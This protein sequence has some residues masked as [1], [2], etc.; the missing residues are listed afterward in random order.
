M[1]IAIVGLGGSYSDYI[2]ARVAS[3]EFDEVWGINCIGAI[4]HVDRTFIIDPVT[5]LITVIDATDKSVI[6]G[7]RVLVT[8]AAGGPLTEGDT[9]IS[10]VTDVNGQASDSRTL[11]SDQPITGKIRL[12]STPGS[13]YKQ[14][15]ISGTISSTSGFSTTVQMIPDE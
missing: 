9:I 13:L 7:A 6:Q 4:I 12:S 3:Q 1:K 11:A 15:N 10:A 8:A 2:S 5:T 14:G